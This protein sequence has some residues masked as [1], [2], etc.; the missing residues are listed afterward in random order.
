VESEIQAYIRQHRATYTREAITAQL[1]AAGHG[2]AD[3]EAAWAAVELEEAAAA[4]RPAARSWR[5]TVG[6]AFAYVGISILIFLVWLFLVF[7][8][9][10]TPATD[11]GSVMLY[12]LPALYLLAI[13]FGVRQG[14]TRP[15]AT[16]EATG[17]LIGAAFMALPFIISGICAVSLGQLV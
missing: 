4:P 2:A 13:A 15:R 8:L 14:L 12:L 17:H 6:I 7:A 11:L 10:S 9:A 5:P 1:Q 3:I 16:P